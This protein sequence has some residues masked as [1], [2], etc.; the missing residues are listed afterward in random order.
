MSR[1][2]KSRKNGATSCMGGL[3]TVRANGFHE[4][5]WGAGKMTDISC[6]RCGHTAQEHGH[7]YPGNTVC[8]ICPCLAYEA[9]TDSD[10]EPP[11]CGGEGGPVLRCSPMSPD[12]YA[13]EREKVR[14]IW[15]SIE[16]TG[17]QK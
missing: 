2:R 1:R 17:D 9:D 8:L 4:R 12:Q 7:T 10:D 5:L 13:A 11:G 16:W 14:A 3:L 15:D 6:C